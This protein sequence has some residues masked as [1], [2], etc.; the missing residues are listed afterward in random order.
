MLKSGS[1]ILDAERLSGRPY[2]VF[3]RIERLVRAMRRAKRRPAERIFV[4]TGELEGL[5]GE[6]R[7]LATF[8]RDRGVDVLFKSV[9]DGHH[10]HN[11]RDQLR[12][13]LRWVLRREAA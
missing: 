4:S 2:S 12:D 11:W 5:A 9:W 3:F 7:A 10:W 8:L 1:F 6:N 13:G